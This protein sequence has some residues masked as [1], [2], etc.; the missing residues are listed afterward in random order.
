MSPVASMVLRWTI[1]LGSSGFV[2]TKPLV[3]VM[4]GLDLIEWA[5]GKIRTNSNKPREGYWMMGNCWARDG[6]GVN[7]MEPGTEIPA[8]RVGW[9]SRRICWYW[10]YKLVTNQPI[11]QLA[12]RGGKG[13]HTNRTRT[14]VSVGTGQVRNQLR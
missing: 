7:C 6:R 14:P 1:R 11:R 12:C 5:L 13:R 9:A 3:Q 8:I 10:Y 4:T 2:T